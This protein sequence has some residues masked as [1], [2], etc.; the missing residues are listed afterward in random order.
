MTDIDYMIDVM[1]HYKNG[2]EV[3]WVMRGYE[4]WNP[5]TNI[6]WDWAGFDY[7]KKPEAKRTRQV[8]L[9]AWFDGYDLF[10][11]PSWQKPLPKWKRAPSEDK[12]FEVEE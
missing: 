6:K 5:A 11:I 2:G 8:T 7:R 12:T 3:E 10:Y 9:L 1:T 4:S